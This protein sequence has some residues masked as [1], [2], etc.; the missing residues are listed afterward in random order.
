MQE[1]Q[2]FLPNTFA[3]QSYTNSELHNPFSQKL[4]ELDHKYNPFNILTNY[5]KLKIWYNKTDNSTTFGVI[6]ISIELHTK[7]EKL[8]KIPFKTTEIQQKQ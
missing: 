6:Q 1:H 3:T 7:S 5:K 2:F 4:K 8:F